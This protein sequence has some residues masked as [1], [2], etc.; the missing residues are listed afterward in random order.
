[1]AVGGDV[2][3]VDGVVVVVVAVGCG[4]KGSR[5]RLMI[6][7]IIWH[8]RAL[9]KLTW[10]T[11]FC[12]ALATAVLLS[13]DDDNPDADGPLVLLVGV[14]LSTTTEVSVCVDDGNSISTKPSLRS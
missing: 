8:S 9:C 3:V 5:H 10:P 2:V 13:K 4:G 1:V 11:R 6:R 12:V 7:S 14:L